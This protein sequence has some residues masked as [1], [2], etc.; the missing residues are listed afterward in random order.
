M[1]AA[2]LA[3]TSALAGLL[4][5]TS[6]AAPARAAASAAFQWKGDTKPVIV[7]E[8]GAWADGSSWAQ[9]IAILQD[10]GVTVYAP[11][12]PLRSL[13]SHSVYL[14][15]FQADAPALERNALVL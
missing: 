13:Q 6:Q 1:L 12:N 14:H 9:V 5:A 8:H 15:D 2:I 11:P 3:V 7:L 10:D 4:T